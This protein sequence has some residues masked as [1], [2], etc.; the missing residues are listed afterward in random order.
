MT[1]VPQIAVDRPGMTPHEAQALAHPS[2]RGIAEALGSSPSGGSA[3]NAAHPVRHRVHVLLAGSR[4]ALGSIAADLDRGIAR[5]MPDGP[6]ADDRDRTRDQASPLLGCLR[7]T[8]VTGPRA[9]ARAPVPSGR[10]ST[11]SNRRSRDLLALAAS[12]RRAPDR[13]CT[14]PGT[15]T[16]SGS[17]V[18]SVGVRRP[19]L[20]PGRPIGQQGEERG[21]GGPAA[22]S[23]GG[24]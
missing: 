16:S 5:R 13:G 17:R 7:P 18:E 23:G 14:C 6:T 11:G 2:R 20:V 9:M 1:I 3:R 4:D 21:V 22:A 12:P 24:S 10:G 8:G 19:V 15:T